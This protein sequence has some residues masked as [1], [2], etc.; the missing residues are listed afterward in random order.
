MNMKKLVEE[1]SQELSASF[2]ISENAVLTKSANPI[3]NIFITGCGG[4]G[5]G[6]SIVAEL[7]SGEATVP[8]SVN[9]DYF[10]PAYV[11][12]NSIALIVSSVFPL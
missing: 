6:G 5:I 2:E 12:N 10:I 3:H 4:S 8:I 9:K 7:V 1:F 11:N